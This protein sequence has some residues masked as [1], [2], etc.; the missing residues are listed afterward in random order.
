MSDVFGR[1]RKSPA[2]EL[3]EAQE[4]LELAQHLNDSLAQF[5]HQLLIHKAHVLMLVEQGILLRDEASAILKAL[6]SLEE[7]IKNEPDLSIYMKA[8]AYVIK[9][10]GPVGGKMHIGRS[11]N[12]LKTTAMRMYIRDRIN[13]IIQNLIKF[14]K[15]LLR[16]AKRNIASIMPGYTHWQHAQPVTFA[17]YILAHADAYERCVER[18]ENAYKLTNLSTPP[19][20]L[21]SGP[22]LSFQ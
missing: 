2:K 17:H 3:I 15:V 6:S 22:R 9:H 18:F 11:R 19:R 8:E 20:T 14:R 13:E 21:K 7:E 1:I 10:A 4:E 12:D 16:L 5:P